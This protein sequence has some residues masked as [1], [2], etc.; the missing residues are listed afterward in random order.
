VLG[1]DF[2]VMAELNKAIEAGSIEDP[3]DN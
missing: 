3:E 2:D 1:D